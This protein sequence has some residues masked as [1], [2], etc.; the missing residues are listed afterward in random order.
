[1]K[2]KTQIRKQN[3]RSSF[4]KKQGHFTYFSQ[5]QWNCDAADT[6]LE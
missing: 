6:E 5:A 2:P 1:M 4:P 3:Y